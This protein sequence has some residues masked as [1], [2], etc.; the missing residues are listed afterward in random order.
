[1]Y[2]IISLFNLA[3]DELESAKVEDRIWIPSLMTKESKF[4]RPEYSLHLEKGTRYAGD[5]DTLVIT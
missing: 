5:K 3:P 4:D 2:T 1:M